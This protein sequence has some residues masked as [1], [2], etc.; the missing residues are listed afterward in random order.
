MRAQAAQKD[1]SNLETET[2]RDVYDAW[3]EANT[4]YEGISVTQQLL[5]SA[6]Q[7]FQLAQSRYQV[8]ASSIVELS[9]ADLQEIQAEITAGTSRF[10]YQVRCRALDFQLG[11]L[12]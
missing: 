5:D 2:A 8:G 3:V 11:R 10:D 12:K 9:Q 4:A 7:A 6:R 1:L